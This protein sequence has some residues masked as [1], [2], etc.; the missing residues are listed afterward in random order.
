MLDSREHIEIIYALR[1]RQNGCHF[2]DDILKYMFLNKN[3]E[4]LLRFDESLF[5]SV[6]LITSALNGL[7]PARRQ[8]IIWINA[9]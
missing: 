5:L 3:Y 7:A 1:P 2:A 4:F 6:Q 8:A 9:G